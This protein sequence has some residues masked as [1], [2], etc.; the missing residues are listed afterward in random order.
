MMGKFMIAWPVTNS[1]ARSLTETVTHAWEQTANPSNEWRQATIRDIALLDL[2]ESELP[3]RLVLT[4]TI[5][6]GTD[7][8][9]EMSIPDP[10]EDAE[11][12]A[13]L[14][15][16]PAGMDDDGSLD[17]ALVDKPIWV[18]QA[19]DDSAV[20]VTSARW[21]R[22]GEW[23]LTSFDTRPQ[24]Y[25][26]IHQWG[27]LLTST[28]FVLDDLLGVWRIGLQLGVIVALALVVTPAWPIVLVGLMILACEEVAL[29]AFR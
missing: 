26:F 14:S 27:R 23:L 24:R 6:D 8:V 25:G 5:A 11:M 18:R 1:M 19:S 13:L 9:W 10:D 20:P 12:A 28:V 4:A 15:Q 2:S 17:G 21:D 3:S 29:L 7:L 22:S 16:V